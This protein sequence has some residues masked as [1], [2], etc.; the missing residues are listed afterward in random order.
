MHDLLIILGN[1]LAAVLA[2]GLLLLLSYLLCCLLG[3][4]VTVHTV[5]Y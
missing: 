3:A 2:F 4:I 5:D 1:L